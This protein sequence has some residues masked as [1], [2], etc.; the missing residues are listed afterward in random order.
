[1]F[2]QDV[3]INEIST[4]KLNQINKNANMLI[5]IMTDGFLRKMD[6][7]LM[8][9]ILKNRQLE[10]KPGLIYNLH[11]MILQDMLREELAVVGLSLEDEIAKKGGKF[12]LG[13]FSDYET[14]II[15]NKIGNLAGIIDVIQQRM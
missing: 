14:N 12:E 7:P 10:N 9:E 1:M 6:Q 13:V 4:E 15:L 5:Q 2:S 3:T 11:V 8:A